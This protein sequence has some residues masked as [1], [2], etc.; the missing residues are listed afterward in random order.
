VNPCCTGDHLWLVGQ[1]GACVG[2]GVGGDGQHPHPPLRGC[3][4]PQ[5]MSHSCG[6]VPASTT[7]IPHSPR[8][9]SIIPK[10]AFFGVANPDLCYFLCCYGTVPFCVKSLYPVTPSC[11]GS[12]FGESVSFLASRKRIRSLPLTTKKIR[13]FFTVFVTF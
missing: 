7:H 3:P 13:D 6:G 4:P 10:P 5:V 8:V 11:S 2:R 1:H 12:R 9:V